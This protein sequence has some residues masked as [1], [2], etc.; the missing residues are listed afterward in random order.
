MVDPPLEIVLLS[1]QLVGGL[2]V[3]MALSSTNCGTSRTLGLK[4]LR[5]QGKGG[6]TDVGSGPGRPAQAH[7]VP[8]RSPLRARGSSSDYA[9]CP[10]HLHDFDDVILAS[11]M[12]VLHV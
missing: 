3:R 7:P 5:V 11:K 9:L 1:L 8:A 6:R 2:L 10:F 4:I 12:E